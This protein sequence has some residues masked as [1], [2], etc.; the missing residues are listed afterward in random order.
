MSIN[1]SALIWKT[2]FLSI[3]SPKIHEDKAYNSCLEDKSSY[4]N[5]ISYKCFVHHSLSVGC[6]NENT[7]RSTTKTD[8]VT[9]WAIQDWAVTQLHVLCNAGQLLQL[10]M[11]LP[12]A[13]KTFL[14]FKHVYIWL[15]I[16]GKFNTMTTQPVTLAPSAQVGKAGD[17]QKFQARLSYIGRPY[18]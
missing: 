1:F 18:V 15:R 13:L 2:H 5:F 10:L 3:H 11:S 7:K 12:K 9:H 14:F 17:N 16:S 6:Y 4:F 8:W